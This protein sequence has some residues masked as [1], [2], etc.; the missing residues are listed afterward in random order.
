M[1]INT[2]HPLDAGYL[3]PTVASPPPAHLST[4]WAKRRH[5]QN[6]ISM[7]AF[8]GDLPQLLPRRLSVTGRSDSFISQWAMNK[9]TTGDRDD[10]LGSRSD[11]HGYFYCLCCSLAGGD[12][13]SLAYLKPAAEYRRGNLTVIA[14]VGGGARCAAST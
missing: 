1:K 12:R 10:T 8:D 13:W 5:E 3:L 7:F 2:C 14:P 6:N 11:A 9:D 4:G